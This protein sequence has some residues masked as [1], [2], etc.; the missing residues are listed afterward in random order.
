M[1][2]TLYSAKASFQESTRAESSQTSSWASASAAMFARLISP[3]KSKHVSLYDEME[4]VLKE[5]ME[6][7]LLLLRCSA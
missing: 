4:G 6:V 1:G 3:C 7:N 2:L 5:G